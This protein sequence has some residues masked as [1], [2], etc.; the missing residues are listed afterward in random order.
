MADT[1]PK[2]EAPM[3]TWIITALQT[4]P[5]LNAL[6]QSVRKPDGSFKY[7]AATIATMIND[8]DWYR[9]NGPTVA[10]KLIDRIKGGENAYREGVNE[11]RQ[12]VSKVATDLGLDATD[13]SVSNY[14][15]ALGENAY[16]HGWTPAQVEGVITS[17]TEIEIGRAS[18]RERVSSPV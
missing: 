2:L 10:Q 6:Y 16:L 7:D 5:E 3:A 11:F 12:S 1:T 8:T 13:P 17:N 9:L 15:S 18:C 4:I 14:I